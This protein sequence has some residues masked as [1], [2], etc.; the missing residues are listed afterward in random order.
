MQLCLSSHK[1]VKI[2]DQRSMTDQSSPPLSRWLWTCSL[3]W[4]DFCLPSSCLK[5]A[6][7]GHLFRLEISLASTSQFAVRWGLEMGMPRLTAIRFQGSLSHSRDHHRVHWQGFNGNIRCRSWMMRSRLH[8]WG[9]HK[10][11]RRC[12]LTTWLGNASLIEPIDRMTKLWFCSS[13][14][15][16]NVDV[17]CETP[18]ELQWHSP[19]SAAFLLTDILSWRS[20]PRP[21]SRTWIGALQQQRCFTRHSLAFSLA[22]LSAGQ[23]PIR[24]SPNRSWNLHGLAQSRRILPLEKAPVAR[25]CMQLL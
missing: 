3:S 20:R 23:L 4:A 2:C 18:T 13:R 25:R 5:F 10:Y 1:P 17:L 24:N 12:R 16:Q 6:L 22:I 8:I 14:C 9:I 19:A 7:T 15:L 21:L 11:S